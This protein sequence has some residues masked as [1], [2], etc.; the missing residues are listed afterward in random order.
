VPTFS[1]LPSSTPHF[2]QDCR[3]LQK[4]GTGKTQKTFRLFQRRKSQNVGFGTCKL[5]G[6]GSAHS[7]LSRLRAIRCNSWEHSL[8]GFIG[9]AMVSLLEPPPPEFVR[10]VAGSFVHSD[11]SPQT[12]FSWASCIIYIVSAGSFYPARAVICGTLRTLRAVLVCTASRRQYIPVK[13]IIIMD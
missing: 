9:I 13:D 2:D 6:V 5:G 10:A 12:F 4:I 11:F 1:I 7:S 3:L 8:C